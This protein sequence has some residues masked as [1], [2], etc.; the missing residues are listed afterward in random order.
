MRSPEGQPLSA[1]VQWDGTRDRSA[2][3]SMHDA[4]R[5]REDIGGDAAIMRYNAD[6]AKW[7]AHYLSS[8]WGTTNFV[9]DEF[10]TSMSDVV[11]P[12][13]N[14]TA[15]NLVVD[16]L[17]LEH[18]IMTSGVGSCSN[19]GDTNTTGILP[20]QAGCHLFRL[21]AQVY[22][23]KADFVKLGH[24]VVELLRRFDPSFQG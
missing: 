2:F 21:S 7:A 11:L 9:S 8:F 14:D 15:L 20:G 12:S 17:L 1:R 3:A 5:F 10:F 18:G 16:A 24:L 6:L 19:P 22:L 23:E 13:A 4:L